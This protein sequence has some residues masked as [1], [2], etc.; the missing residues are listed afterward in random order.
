M[1]SLKIVGGVVCGILVVAGGI[2]LA[3]KTKYGS[4][5]FN[6]VKNLGGQIKNSFNEGYSEAVNN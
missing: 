5:I 4:E 3:R 2:Y 6:S 1:F